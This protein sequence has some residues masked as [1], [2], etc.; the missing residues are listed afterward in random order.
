[1]FHHTPRMLY[2]LSHDGTLFISGATIWSAQMS[3]QTADASSLLEAESTD[4]A[5]WTLPLSQANVLRA[6]IGQDVHDEPATHAGAAALEHSALLMSAVPGDDGDLE[7]SSSSSFSASSVHIDESAQRSSAATSCGEAQAL[8]LQAWQHRRVC[9]TGDSLPL[10][11][12]W[13]LL[14]QWHAS[15][16][17]QA[18]HV[19]AFSA[20]TMGAVLALSY[21]PVA[22]GLF[23]GA[24]AAAFLWLDVR[25]LATIAPLLVVQTVFGSWAAFNSHSYAP[26]IASSILILVV[27]PSLLVVGHVHGE[28]AAAATWPPSPVTTLFTAPAL[29]MMLLSRRVTSQGTLH[30]VAIEV[31]RRSDMKYRSVARR[32]FGTL[33][34]LRD[35]VTQVV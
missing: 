29:C 26:A 14:Y 8:V 20:W 6:E 25:F 3:D 11:D 22:M 5:S 10:L 7:T 31:V 35:S 16:A 27:A 2:N 17:N 13:A 12:H 21:A 34:D 18:A 33:A 19:V 15:S 9:G 24:C 4:D 28:R 23:I 32:R 30:I 1:M